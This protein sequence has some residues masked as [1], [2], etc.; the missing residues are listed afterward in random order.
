MSGYPAGGPA[1]VEVI[2]AV[3]RLGAAKTRLAPV[4]SAAGR[5]NIVLAMLVDTIGAASAVPAVR[6]HH[7]RHTRRDGRR[8]RPRASARAW[9]PTPPRKATA[10]R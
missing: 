4:L 3:K 6:A 1:D 9:W 7:H 10:T 8:D 5:E 2:I